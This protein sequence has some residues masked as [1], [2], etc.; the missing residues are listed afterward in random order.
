MQVVLSLHPAEILPLLASGVINPGE[1]PAYDTV[2]VAVVVWRKVVARFM[3]SYTYTYGG[4]VNEVK[5]SCHPIHRMTHWRERERETSYD[6][7]T[8]FPPSYKAEDNAYRRSVEILRMV[9]PLFHD[10]VL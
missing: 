10:L 5:N 2:L 1:S 7:S 3:N 6:S 4:S 9:H 8:P